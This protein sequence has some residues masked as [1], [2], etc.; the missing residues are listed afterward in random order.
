MVAMEVVLLIFVIL[1]VA[2]VDVASLP[3]V[4][5]GSRRCLE[6]H[7]VVVVLGLGHGVLVC[8]TG[9]GWRG[10]FLLSF[11]FSRLLSSVYFSIP[12]YSFFFPSFL[13]RLWVYLVVFLLTFLFRFY[14]FYKVDSFRVCCASGVQRGRAVPARL[15]HVAVCQA[16]E[17]Y[18]STAQR[19]V[20]EVPSWRARLG[21]EFWHADEFRRSRFLVAREA[22]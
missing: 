15:V 12:F 14:S 3:S 20:H 22:G 13:W 10:L 17:Q 16:K 6:G 2:V 21:D 11:Y 5:Q 8:A 1:V 18:L 7:Q 9:A 4:F 19:V